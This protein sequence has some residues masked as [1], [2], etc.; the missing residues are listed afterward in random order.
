MT[1]RPAAPDSAFVIIS[2]PKEVKLDEHRVALTPAGVQELVAAG[3]RVLVQEEAGA[4]SGFLDEEY[5]RAG[6]TLVDRERA[7]AEADLILKVKEPQVSE[8]ELLRP[9]CALFTYLHL[10]ANPAVRA[11]LLQKKITALAYESL[12][13]GAT[14]P[15]LAPMSEIAGRMA[16][17]MG[18]MCLQRHHGGKGVLPSGAIGT[19]RARVLILGA[20]VVGSNAARTAYGMG[21]DVTVMSITDGKLERIDELHQGHVKTL[22]LTTEALLENCAR[23]DMIIGAVLLPNRRTPIMLNLEQVRALQPGSVLVDVSVDQGGCFATTRP[24][25]HREPNYLQEGVVHYCVANMPGAYPRTATQALT[26]QTLPFVL[27]L[28]AGVEAGLEANEVLRTALNTR[29]GR[30]V[31]PDLLP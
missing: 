4:G 24:T 23:A 8:F 6:A 2:V 10:A 16:P 25:T 22:V 3:V 14:L 28:A 9:G 7:F 5:A 26:N 27:A 20:G 15:L 29:D 19:P 12:R 30:I 21:M 17:L 11:A 18:A 31:L 13:V 1:G